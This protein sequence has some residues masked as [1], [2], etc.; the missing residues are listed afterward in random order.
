MA[1][2]KLPGSDDGA[3]ALAVNKPVG[4]SV[5][6]WILL[7]ILLIV[8]VIVDAIAELMGQDE[9]GDASGYP[10]HEIYRRQHVNHVRHVR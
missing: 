3:G 7:F 6:L 2:K 5:M 8:L 9:G 4:A 10:T 1:S